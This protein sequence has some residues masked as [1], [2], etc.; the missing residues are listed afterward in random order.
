MSTIKPTSQSDR[1]E[2]K[3]DKL[4]ERT[5]ILEVKVDQLQE[6]V[7]VIRKD[8][9]GIKKDVRSIKNTL[10]KV[11]EVVT[12]NQGNLHQRVKSLEHHTSHPPMPFTISRPH[13]SLLTRITFSLFSLRLAGKGNVLAR[14]ARPDIES[15]ISRTAIW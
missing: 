7:V 8:I 2:T 13:L 12:K 9:V 1:I 6:D 15:T 5:T 14:N 11:L 4:T 10:E 3:V